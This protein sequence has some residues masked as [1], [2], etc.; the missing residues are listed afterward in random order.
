MTTAA[1]ASA[2]QPSLHGKHLLFLVTEDWYFCSHRLPLA[3]AALAAGA[4]VS[5][6]CQVTDHAEQIRAEGVNLIPLQIQ[7]SGRNPLIDFST[8]CQIHRVYRQER[9]DI[10]HHVALKPVLYGSVVAWL[11]GTKVVINAMAGL[12]FVFIN[13]S[14]SV[15]ALRP[16]IAL[17][18]KV[19]LNRP[20]SRLIV[21]NPDDGSLFQDEI[22]VRKEAI[23][24]IQGSGVD[25]VHYQAMPEPPS[26]PIVVAC[27][28]RMLWD[29][30]IGELVD[31]ARILKTRGKEITIKLIGPTDDNPASIPRDLLENWKN[32]GIVEVPGPTSDIAAVYRDAHI[33]VLPSY[34]EGLP[35]SL[36]EAAACGRPS[37]STDV[38][39]CRE[40]CVDQ[41]TGLLVPARSAEP[42]AD[43]IEKLAEDAELRA[44]LGA[45]ARKAAEM[46][47]SEQ[48]IADQTISL[49]KSV[50]NGQ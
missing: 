8:L 50:L 28:S 1:P 4:R 24:L 25:T 22:G 34:R 37:V 6:A 2:E 44:S 40:I 41:M 3:R 49:Y 30:G 12:G 5:V 16:A 45:G 23:A 11:A 20:N 9:P 48:T 31:A 46:R 39:G 21:Q 15:R 36:L 32:T 38:P 35:K 43:A 47:F 27:V 29:K 10:V 26:P 13:E 17:A 7:R 14:F 33:A 18:F 42:I 19:L